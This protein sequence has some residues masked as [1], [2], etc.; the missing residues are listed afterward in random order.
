MGASKTATKQPDLQVIG[1]ADTPDLITASK[2]GNRL[3]TLI[4]LRDFLADKLQNTGSSRDIS[5]M[6]RR[7]MQCVT[8]IE[9]LQK[10]KEALEERG[11]HFREMQ[12]RLRMAAARMETAYKEGRLDQEH[13]EH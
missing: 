8:E 10:E 12:K 6:S 11:G 1:P 7:L 9:I 13:E 5:S 3:E 2:S 4:A